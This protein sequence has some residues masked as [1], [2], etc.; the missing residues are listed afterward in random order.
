MRRE[1]LVIATKS[2]ARDGAGVR[3]HLA[4]SLERLGVNVIALYQLH[5][6]SNQEQ[7]EKI[8]APGGPLDVA[9]EA[10]AAGQVRHIGVT[11]HSME[12][13]LQAVRS[14]HFETLMFPFNFI[15]DEAAQE[16]IPL[17]VRSLSG[18]ARY[19]LVVGTDDPVERR[20]ILGVQTGLS[21]HRERSHKTEQTRSS[22]HLHIHEPDLKISGG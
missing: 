18:R 8:L 21:E 16:L 19:H 5:G 20:H 6:V 14:G 1:G 13:A 15:T 12:M 9:H 7:W 22:Y 2:G 11:S 4:L 17:A 10:Q 3:E